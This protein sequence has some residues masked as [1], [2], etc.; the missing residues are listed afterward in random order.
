MDNSSIAKIPFLKKE[1]VLV[2]R[3]MKKENERLDAIDYS[4]LNDEEAAE[5][6]QDHETISRICMML[7][8][9]LKD[10]FGGA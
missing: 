2:L 9:Y 8:R 3:V 5:T 6:N 7:D 1:L 10:S 4:K